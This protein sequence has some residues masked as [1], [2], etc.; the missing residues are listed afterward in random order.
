MWL[1][2][3]TGLSYTLSPNGSLCLSKIKDNEEERDITDMKKIVWEIYYVH[4]DVIKENKKLKNFL[5]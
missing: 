2:T 1:S 3:E 5:T 4:M